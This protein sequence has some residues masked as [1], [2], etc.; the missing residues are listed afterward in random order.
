MIY[1]NLIWILLFAFA[2]SPVPAHQRAAN[3]L[4]KSYAQQT[5]KTDGLYLIGLGGGFSDD[6]KIV[7]YHYGT[8]KSLDVNDARRLYVKTAQNLINRMNSDDNVR[9]Y[10]HT[11]PATIDN[12]DIS[13]GFFMPNGE[14]P[15]EEHVALMFRTRGLIFYEARKDSKFITLYEETWEEALRKVCEDIN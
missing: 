7:S 2:C 1:L 11:Y 6:I 4:L 8:I 9:P 13:I 12:V 5:L 3:I 14:Y 15:D 10:L